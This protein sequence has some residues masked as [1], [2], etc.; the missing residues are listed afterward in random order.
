[1]MAWGMPKLSWLLVLVAMPLMGATPSPVQV[2]GTSSNLCNSARIVAPQSASSVTLRA[3][4]SVRSAKAGIL[5]YDV[6]IYV[7]DERGEWYRIFYAGNCG[8]GH[9]QGLKSN[10]TRSCKSGWIP[11]KRVEVISG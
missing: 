10:E 2:S 6:P 11:R 4:P 8:D 3:R 9:P 5:N 7:C 1:M